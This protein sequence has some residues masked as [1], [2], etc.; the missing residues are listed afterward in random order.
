[1]TLIFF[2]NWKFSKFINRKK[3]YIYR[4][5]SWKKKRNENWE[6]N[7]NNEMKKEFYSWSKSKCFRTVLSSSLFLPHKWPL[8]S[9]D[10]E[11]QNYSF[12][13]ATL[14]GGLG[15]ANTKLTKSP[16]SVSLLLFRTKCPHC[17]SVM[18]FKK[19]KH[20]SECHLKASILYQYHLTDIVY[21]IAHLACTNWIE[22]F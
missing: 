21:Y 16:C 9:A 22:L 7:W 20:S 8:F 15:C 1:M 18:T 12:Y 6:F 17:K 11:V 10:A 14:Q 3:K 19:S 4:I 5:W 13:K 2:Q